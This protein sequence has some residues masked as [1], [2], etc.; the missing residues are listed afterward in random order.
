MLSQYH[1]GHGLLGQSCWIG[2]GLQISTHGRDIV[3][4]RSGKQPISKVSPLT[5]LAGRRQ[6]DSDGSPEHVMDTGPIG[7]AHSPT[8]RCHTFDAKA[9]GYIKAEAVNAIVLKRLDDAIRDRDPIRAVIRGSATNSDGRTPGIASPDSS[10]QAAAVRSAYANAGIADLGATSYLECHGTGTPAGDP[11]EVQGVSSVFADSRALSEPLVIGS[12]KSNLGHSEPAAGLSGLF[13]AILAI[14]HGVIPGNPTFE[15][16][17]PKIN[18]EELKIRAT[19]TA[20]PWPDSD[21]RRASI[22]SFGYGGTNSHVILDELKMLRPDQDPSYVSSYLSPDDDI[23]EE[24]ESDRPYTLV[25]SANDGASLQSYVETLDKHLS[26]LDV[27]VKLRD[28]AYTLSERRSHHFHRGYIVTKGSQIDCKTMVQSK[29]SGEQP[30][31]GFVLTGQGAQ[32]SQMG[33]AVVDTFPSAIPLLERLDSALQQLPNPPSWSLLHELTEPRT[34]EHLR[35]PEFSQPL[36]T[37]LQLVLLSVFRR[38]GIQPQSVVGHSSGEI[39]AACAAGYISEEDAIKAAF[40]RGQS[41]KSC[42]TKGEEVVGMLA[43]GLGPSTVKGYLSGVQTQVQIACYNSPKSVTLSGTIACLEDVKG[44]L[45]KDGH[46][47]RLLQVDLAYHSKYMARIGQE[48]EALLEQNFKPL[49]RTSGTVKMFS[50]VH[51]QKMSAL[52]DAKYWKANMISAVKFEDACREMLIGRN[53]ADFLIEI[54]PSGALA[55]P[56]S[57]IKESMGAEGSKVQY[58]AALSRGADSIN[59]LFHVAG[60]LHISGAPVALSRVNNGEDASLP[61]PCV[62]TDLPNYV[63]NH[64]N[65]YWHENQASKDWRFRRFLEHD[66]L[67]TKVLATP[68][69]SPSFRKTLLLERLPWLRS[70]KMR[71]DVIFPAAGYIAMA[72]EAIYQTHTIQSSETNRGYSYAGALQYHLRNIK[73]DKALVLEEGTESKLMLSLNPLAGTKDTWYEFRVSSSND[74]TTTTH[75]CT[76]LVRTEG[77]KVQSKCALRDALV[78]SGLTCMQVPR[79]R[80]WPRS[81]IR[82]QLTCGTKPRPKSAT[83]SVQ[84]SRSCFR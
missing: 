14:E 55:G 33:K 50:S 54:G 36:V 64:N 76:G 66:L 41:A 78:L 74:G 32:W 63:W 23:F 53:G 5:F 1:R 22:N 73:F 56:I 34:G 12:I 48:Y 60:K 11:L 83:A 47:A 35:Q 20:I 67:G 8:G 39:A 3:S 9:D 59:S 57:Q 16:P 7:M 4:Y 24:E 19:R 49:D 43:V 70:H 21:F 37:A 13:K 10:A 61:L 30:R 46:F 62:I 45:V 44:R 27:K 84:I 17:N 71:T 38:W 26:S 77:I 80:I 82:R 58:C 31:I 15:T 29:K 40:Y 18:F 75:H 69:H 79:K 65:K 42:K 2:H 72:M 25:F 28:L 81:C 68:W 6:T 51:G 52:T